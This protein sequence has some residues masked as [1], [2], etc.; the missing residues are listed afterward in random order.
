[1]IRCNKPG[2]GFEEAAIDAVR[3]WRYKP[4]LKDGQPL[5]V[6]FTIVVDFSLH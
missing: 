4:A 2:L 1:M 3:Q 6:Y 5:D